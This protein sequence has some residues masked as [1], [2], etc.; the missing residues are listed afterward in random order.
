MKKIFLL[1]SLA[2]L[3]IATGCGSGK[4][5]KEIQTRLL[6]TSP[7][8]KDTTIVKDYVCQIRSIRHIELRA[9]ERGYLQEIFV[10]EGQH[11]KKGQRMFQIMP[12]MYNAELQKVQAEAR[13]AE[14]E[15]QTTKSLADKNV[16][17]KSELA[18][19]RAK[20]EK[21]KA[22]VSLAQ[23]HLGFTKI[24]APF[25]GIMDRFQVR[26]GSLVEEGD[27]LTT[28]SDNSEM[29]VYFNVPE[30]EYL[31]F[32]QNAKKENG[33]S[34]SLVMANNE[35][36][37]HKATFPNPE[38]LLR[39]GETGNIQMTAPLKNAIIIP[40]KATYEVLDKKY[41]F[42]V[43]KNSVV[44]SREITIGADLPDLYIVSK[45]LK[46]GEKILLEGIRKVHDG[47]KI[48]YKYE[49][50]SKVISHLKVYVE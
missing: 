21:A 49:Q 24:D 48:Q 35:L 36:F 20:Y 45:G 11:V 47:Q 27:L 17:S 5:E 15:L 10:D 14:I 32:Q 8:Q 44:H 31:E 3:L 46:K 18:M 13:L 41:V 50:P 30:P 7:L 38:G 22:E 43:D 4:S 34:V 26:L 37:S 28:L 25:D 39:H 33:M 9:L 16:V 12:L 29:W 40:Q 2:V 42:V 6:V 23:V 19:A 1:S